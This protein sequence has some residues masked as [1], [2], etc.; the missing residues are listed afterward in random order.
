MKNT[1]KKQPVKFQ[2]ETNPIMHL[3]GLI[4]AFSLSYF[5]FPQNLTS[6]PKMAILVLLT[7]VY[8]NVA[9]HIGKVLGLLKKVN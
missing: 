5:S 8:V 6:L 1:E 7:F 2:F 4:T 9:S 3:T